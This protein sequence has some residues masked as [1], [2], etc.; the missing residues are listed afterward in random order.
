MVGRYYFDDY[1]SKL[2]LPQKID[3]CKNY[4]I[5]SMPNIPNTVYLHT[6][7][8]SELDVDTISGM[9]IKFGEFV[10]KNIIWIGI[11]HDNPE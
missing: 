3:L 4:Y 10:P 9:T 8:Q 2:T 11:E 5:N 7:K 1:D 6:N